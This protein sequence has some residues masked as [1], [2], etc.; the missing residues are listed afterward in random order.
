MGIA[1]LFVVVAIDGVVYKTC[2]AISMSARGITI[3][4]IFGSSEDGNG[5]GGLKSDLDFG[6]GGRDDSPWDQTCQNTSVIPEGHRKRDK[7][8]RT[9]WW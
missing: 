8:E 5:N 4:P 9:S 2:A 6:P 3:S 1:S 7:R